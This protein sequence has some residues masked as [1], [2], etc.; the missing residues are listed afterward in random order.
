MKHFFS[1]HI[2]IINLCI[3]LN[4]VALHIVLGGKC[5]WYMSLFDKLLL[6]SYY[7]LSYSFIPVS[8]MSFISPF[9]NVILPGNVHSYGAPF[10]DK[11]QIVRAVRHRR[12]LRPVSCVSAR[13]D[14]KI[15]GT[16]LWG[17]V[18]K[19]LARDGV[20]SL[21][22]QYDCVPSRSHSHSLSSSR[23]AVAQVQ[24]IILTFH[25]RKFLRRNL[26]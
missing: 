12:P 8:D 5:S 14:C 16:E 7:F 9:Q 25:F 19:R 3:A 10:V 1:K 26:Y 21:H 6:D 17:R 24:F 20:V 4:L 22:A 15:S 13:I 2:T 18:W 23:R 11:D